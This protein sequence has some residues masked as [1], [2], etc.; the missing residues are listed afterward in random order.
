MIRLYLMLARVSAFL[1]AHRLSG[2]L[3]YHARVEELR[4]RLNRRMR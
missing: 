2:W 4:R 3:T 1:G